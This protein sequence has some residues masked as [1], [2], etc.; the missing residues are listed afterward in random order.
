MREDH[1]NMTGEEVVVGG[2]SHSHRRWTTPQACYIRKNKGVAKGQ[3][4]QEK[5]WVACVESDVR[6]FNIQQNWKHAARDAQRWT[7]IV[8][9][10]G[11]R[12][13]TEWRKDEEEKYKTHQ[14]KRT[15]KKHENPLRVV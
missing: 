2:G 9:E 6:F 10:G 1:G 7:E 8:T 4:G 12:F 15:A 13:M 11:R 14:E 3:G 5:E